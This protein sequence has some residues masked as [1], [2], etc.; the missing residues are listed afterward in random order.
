MQPGSYRNV[1]TDKI[2]WGTPAADAVAAEVDSLGA[3][4]AFLVASKTLSRST[5]EIG[6]IRKT[7]GERFAGLFDRCKE[8]TP[9]ESVIDCA[10]AARSA[11][12]DLIVTIGGGTPFDTVKIVQL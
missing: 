3:K 8:H 1:P 12:A 10:A 6:K 9:L 7:L 2:V 5:E 4:R 11:N